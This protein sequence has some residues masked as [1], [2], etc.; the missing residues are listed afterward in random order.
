[1]TPEEQDGELE[2]LFRAGRREMPRAEMRART[3]ERAVASGRETPRTRRGL[4]LGFGLAAAAGLAVTLGLT[5]RHE[6]SVSVGPELLP[7]SAHVNPTPELPR[8]P[9][10]T[11]SASPNAPASAT[12]STSASAPARADKPA[13]PR[14]APTLGEEIALLQSARAALDAR[15]GKQALVLLDRYARTMHGARLG[16]EATVLRLEALSRVGR[17]QEAAELARAF[18]AAHPG[19]PLVDRA[20]AFVTPPRTAESSTPGSTP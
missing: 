15:D 2:R 5:R 11:A 14:P 9:A 12:P 13:A 7:P 20:R 3:L 19:S 10:T 18:V 16:D 1:M 6:T 8:Q 4:A 17:T